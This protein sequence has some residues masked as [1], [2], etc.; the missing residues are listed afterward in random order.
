MYCKGQTKVINS[1]SQR[2]SNSVWRRRKCLKCSAIFT[3]T[4][5]A[6][7]AQG[8]SVKESKGKT[9]PFSSDHL[10]LSVYD[11]LKHRPTAVSDARS[12]VDTVLNKLIDRMANGIIDVR[13]ISEVTLVCLNRFDKVASVHYQAYY[14]H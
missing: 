1:R 10:Y 3:T 4:E 2:R 5:D 9:I 11:S 13:S 7:I 12:L 8:W 6:N 14:L